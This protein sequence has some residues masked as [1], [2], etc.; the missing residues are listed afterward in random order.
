MTTTIYLIRHGEANNP[1]GIIYGRLPKFGLSAL[2]K[3]EAEE[4]AEFLKDKDISAIYSSPLERT[5]QTA[6][7][8]QKQLGLKE[9]HFSEQITEG[10]TSYEGK[11]FKS[12]DKLQSEV[13]LKPLD[14]SDETLDEI[15]QRM[16]IFLHG[17]INMNDGKQVVI[18][19][20]GDPIMALKAKIKHPSR[21]LEFL[22]FKTDNYIQHA[23]VYAI[24]AEDNQLTLK[25]AFKPQIED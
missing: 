14:P 4:V 22:S 5:K 19:S 10:K 16:M 24:T 17:V 25:P 13:Y 18:V 6:E 11:K 15:A 2:G 3:K 8:I 12:L 1:E 21:P 23:E 7:I 20:H 9:I